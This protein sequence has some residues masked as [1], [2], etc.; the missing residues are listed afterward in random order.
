MTRVFPKSIMYTINIL[1][2]FKKS[3]VWTSD[4]ALV[5]SYMNLTGAY[6]STNHTVPTDTKPIIV[7][8]VKID[9]SLRY[10]SNTLCHSI[11]LVD[12]VTRGRFEIVRNK[13]KTFRR[14]RQNR[15]KTPLADRTIDQVLIT[16]RH[17]PSDCVLYAR[18]YIFY[19][20]EII[21]IIRG[22]IVFVV[23][24]RKVFNLNTRRLRTTCSCILYS[25][26]LY[27][28]W[29]RRRHFMSRWLS[30]IYVY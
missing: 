3:T 5:F 9:Q 22:G 23:E 19:R 20:V 26:A 29:L 11:F 6:I 21:T 28:S 24:R 17:I 13:N 8:Y 27:R 18:T 1:R 7:S 2:S 10:D 25:Y 30:F 4:Y 16:V 12:N 15:V 14:T